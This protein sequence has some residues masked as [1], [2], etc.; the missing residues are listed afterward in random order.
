MILPLVQ[1]LLFSFFG[2]LLFNLGACWDR[3]PDLDLDQGLTIFWAAGP[4][5]NQNKDNM[6]TVRAFLGPLG[7]L[8]VALSVCMSVCNTSEL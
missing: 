5:Y 8:A 7:P 6:K 2:G 3:G 4:A 1:I